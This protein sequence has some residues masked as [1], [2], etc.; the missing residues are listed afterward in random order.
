[1][2]VLFFLLPLLVFLAVYIFLPQ[3]RKNL[4][5]LCGLIAFISLVTM[6]YAVNS[7]PLWNDGE[8]I[9]WSGLK[10]KSEELIIGGN[11]ETAVVGWANG[12]FAPRV[13]ASISGQQT[14][15]EISGSAGFVRNEA[16]NEYLNGEVVSVENFQTIGKY[17]FKKTESYLCGTR[18]NIL[19]NNNLL[20][21]INL[22]ST[23]KDRVY[24]LD[25][26]VDRA[27]QNLSPRGEKKHEWFC[28]PD[29]KLAPLERIKQIEELKLVLADARLLLRAGGEIRYLSPQ[30]KSEK[31][32]DNPCRIK[33]LWSNSS[34]SAEFDKTPKRQQ[35]SL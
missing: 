30:T 14:K 35:I 19:R 10:S 7:S 15:L 2:L 11:A 32:C 12:S 34:V 33:V 3:Q 17:D 25:A 1:M 26:V 6:I 23:A 24:N 8:R 31:A 4:P 16:N 5:L 22:P 18:L 13:K 27:A 29:F 20:V 9:V 21:Q 28:S